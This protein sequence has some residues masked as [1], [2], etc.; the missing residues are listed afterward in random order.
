MYV[1]I[2]SA[3]FQMSDKNIQKVTGESTVSLDYGSV[4]PGRWNHGAK[5][6]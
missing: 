3:V 4:T 2:H 5:Y 6:R 1:V